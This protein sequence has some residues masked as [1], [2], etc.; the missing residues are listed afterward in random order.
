[1][2]ALQTQSFGS[3]SC[4]DDC[5]IHFPDGIFGFESCHQWLLLSDSAH[6]A[7]YWLQSVERSDLSL[8]VVDPRE[9]VRDYSVHISAGQLPGMEGQEQPFVVLS[10]LTHLGDRLVLNL[11]NPILIDPSCLKG[12]Q[13]FDLGEQPIQY[14]LSLHSASAKKCA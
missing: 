13:V 12:W 10:V 14:E 6:G 4:S 8:S 9:F 1:M 3:V 2:K 5:L 11:K 7:L